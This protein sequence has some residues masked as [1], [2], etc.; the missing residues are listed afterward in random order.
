MDW[1]EIFK[2]IGLTSAIQILFLIVIGFFGKKLFE[3][4]ISSSVEVKKLELNQSLEEYKNKLEIL[5]L[6]HEIK[7]SSLHIKRL[8]V[9]ESLYKRIVNVNQS[10]QVYTAVLKAGGEN[11]EKEEKKRVEK[12]NSDFID[13]VSYYTEHKIY[14]KEELCEIFENIKNLLW[15]NAA[16]YSVSID[17]IK[18][19]GMDSET[20]KDFFEKIKS[21]SKKIREEIP[22]M[23]KELEKEF[24]ILIGVN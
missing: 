12:A 2:A 18:M 15:E 24:R 5:R 16:E 14:F 13:F 1:I 17:M 9:I 7:Y 21:A 20:K 10:M 23:E 19:P 11:F 6:E 3:Y 22:K 4:F 8:D